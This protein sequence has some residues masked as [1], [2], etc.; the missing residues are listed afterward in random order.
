M[1]AGHPGKQGRVPLNLKSASPE[2]PATLPVKDSWP[3][4]IRLPSDRRTVYWMPL[5]VPDTVPE[6]P[7]Q[8]F[9]MVKVIPSLVMVWNGGT[10]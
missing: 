1:V 9:P 7:W 8:I 10:G 5:T 6:Y 4:T 2:L 3:A